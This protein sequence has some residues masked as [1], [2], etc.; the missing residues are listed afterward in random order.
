MSFILE[1]FTKT[2][3]EETGEIV[4]VW[5]DSDPVQIIATDKKK[6]FKVAS[7]QAYQDSSGSMTVEKTTK[8][9][10]LFV[11]YKERGFHRQEAGI[12]LSGLKDKLKIYDIEIL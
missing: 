7:N 4:E 6:K 12:R 11:T 10:S 8:T 1:Q 2:K 5:T 9:V 3:N